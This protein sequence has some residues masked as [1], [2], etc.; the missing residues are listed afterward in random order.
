MNDAPAGAVRTSALV[1]LIGNPNTGKT[2]LFN[3]LTGLR[4]K[5][6]NYPGVTVEK[7]SGPLR[8]APAGC[9][10][11]ILDLPGAYSLS[12]RSLDER[13]AVDVLSG[14]GHRRPD[15]VV[16]VVDATNLRR[17][18]FL[19]SQVA[20]LG[21][22]LVLVLNQVDA[23]RKQG[24]RFDLDRLEAQLG[25]PVVPTVAKRGE[26]VDAL[27]DAIHRAL[28]E[29]RRMA[30]IAWPEAVLEARSRLRAVTPGLTDGD[31]TRLLFDSGGAVARRVA[32]NGGGL[33]AA[34]RE[35]REA[36]FKAGLNPGP[37]EAVLH[38]AHLDGLLEATIE[39]GGAM[40]PAHTESIDRLLLHRCWGTA[41]FL[42]VMWAVFQSVY[43]WSGPLMDG[44][45]ALTGRAQALVAPGLAG[46]PTLQSLV[47]DGILGGVGGVVVFLPQ[48]FLLF[49]W[50]GLLE[51]TGYMARAAFLMDRLFGWCGLN[52]KSF[53]P[54]LSSY[55]CA[56]PGVMAARTMEDPKARLTTIL[57][58]PFMSCSARLPVYVLLIGAFIEP[59]SGAA[60]AG[61]V[62]FAMHFVG[63]AVSLPLA[64]FFNRVLLRVEPLPFILEMPPYR[65]PRWRDLLWRMWERGQEF[66]LRAGTVILA[67]SVIIWALLY[68]PRGE[69]LAARETAA[70]IAETA[71]AAGVAPAEIEA[72]LADGDS[73]LVAALAHRIEGAQ[74][75][76]SYLGRFGKTVQPLFAPAGFDWKI[77]VSI[78]SS[79]PAREVIIAT[80][81]I[82]Y[83]LGPE[84]DEESGSLRERMAA[85]R[86]AAGPRAGMPVFTIPVVLAIMVFFAL[87]LQCGAT[88]AVIRRELDWRWAAAAF[89]GMTLL[90][91]IGAVVTYQFG[92]RWFA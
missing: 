83:R 59:V 10:V 88:V 33:E 76:Q 79:F 60:V 23:A 49:F 4:Q 62:L 65:A 73:E 9:A 40:G 25:V 75:E 16:C 53:V 86:W 67:F 77:T 87:C 29:P 14:V 46:T 22:P 5:I 13:I 74:V 82:I 12:A 41:V 21:L 71:A 47:V 31:A 57:M 85:E 64:W 81:G 3:H 11:E 24:L 44:I 80:L 39:E 38:Y 15:L 32:T 37:A 42:G 68:F 52:G 26:G 43:T 54:L 27:I 50:I 58:A 6:A 7:K 70:L 30:P 66:L 90:A 92:A 84:I 28:R 91:W 89:A 63:L 36:L 78:L 48:I 56:I 35:G 18:L 20:D 61:W 1:A 51:D 69:S 45:E 2:T 8:R 34:I 19:A 17:N 55:A 72:R